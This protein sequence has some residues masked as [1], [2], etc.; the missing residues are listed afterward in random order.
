[1]KFTELL[2][3]LTYSEVIPHANPLQNTYFLAD[4]YTPTKTI[5]APKS[6]TGVKNSW[7]NIPQKKATTGIKYVTEVAKTGDEIW[8][9][10]KKMSLPHFQI[11]ASSIYIESESD[12]LAKKFIFAYKIE[13]KNQN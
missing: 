4:K 1:M 13:I 7:S 6:C 5:K 10:L 2:W 12:P 11:S 3:K 9:S 8:M